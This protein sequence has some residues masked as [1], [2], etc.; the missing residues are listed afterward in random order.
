MAE[1][2][3]PCILSWSSSQDV[4]TPVAHL[5]CQGPLQHGRDG[6]LQHLF[7]TILKWNGKEGI[8][9]GHMKRTPEEMIPPVAG[10]CLTAS[11]SQRWSG[12][13]SAGCRAVWGEKGLGAS[14]EGPHTFLLLLFTGEDVPNPLLTSRPWGQS[15]PHSLGQRSGIVWAQGYPSASAL[16][17]A[18]GPP[19]AQTHLPPCSCRG[20]PSPLCRG[21]CWS[22]KWGS[23]SFRAFR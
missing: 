6:P 1:T 15:L 3:F 14:E 13:G 18:W 22:W 17:P 9:L 16:S 7:A 21:L 8:T 23:F 20:S 10:L 19:M 11:P 12:P 5:C 4:P 2:L